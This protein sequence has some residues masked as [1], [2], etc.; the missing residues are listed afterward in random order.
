MT[1]IGAL[2]GT[3]R[4]EVTPWGAI[5]PGDGSSQLEWLVAAEDRWHRPQDEASVR[6][7]LVD[8]TPVVETRLRVP[9]GDVVHRATVV[10]DH[11]GITLIE[12]TNESP[13]P[14]A[15]ALTRADLWLV[16]PPTD[17]PTPG[18]DLPEGSVVLPLGH[19]ATLRAGLP[20]GAHGHQQLPRDLPD[21]AAVARSWTAACE[22]AGRLVMPDRAMVQTWTAA[23]SQA[24]LTLTD[25]PVADPLTWLLGCHEA[26]RLGEPASRWLVETAGAVERLLRGRWRRRRERSE[27]GSDVQWDVW[28]AV[29]AA[30]A[31]I[32][33]SGDERALGDATALR[34]RFATVGAPPEAAPDGVRAAPWCEDR[35]VRPLPQ[36][37][38]ALFPGGLPR[39][40]FGAPVEVHDLDVGDGRRVSFAL[41]WHGERPA[42]LW[43]STDPSP[44]GTVLYGGGLDP[45]WSSGQRSGEA[46]LAV[47]PGAPPVP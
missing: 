22:R 14:V 5:V 25:D 30:H 18:T 9:G 46:L 44:D 39:S 35:L 24:A 43:E 7:R 17:V 26:V 34:G 28:R 1:T 21:T 15:V 47:P 31:V 38:L 16:R 29:L 45:S 33:A 11:G 6:Q 41:R 13:L 23:R 2:G 8:G 10:P 40:W 36:G 12:V 32:L 20:H 19:R 27:V 3:R 4:D 42:L 37:G